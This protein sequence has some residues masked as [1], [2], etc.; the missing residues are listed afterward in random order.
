M[1]KTESYCY[2]KYK[3]PSN[4]S[5][6]IK[7]KN[8]VGKNLLEGTYFDGNGVPKTIGITKDEYLEYK[9]LQQENKKL[10]GAIQ[11][12]DILLKSNVEEN[13]RLKDNW[14]KLKEYAKE[15]TSTDN[16]LYGTDLLDKMQELEQGSDS[17][18]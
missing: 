4:N 5:C 9:Q 13:K 7:E 15:V 11:T 16:E 14:N 8:I 18:V 10:N 6:V 3:S 12:Y 17:N 2:Q 1:K